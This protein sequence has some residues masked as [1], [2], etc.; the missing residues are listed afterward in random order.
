MGFGEAYRE[1]RVTV[2]GDLVDAAAAAFHALAARQ[3]ARP[4]REGHGLWEARDNVHRHYDLGND[5]Y[6]AWLDE[7]LVYTCAYFPSAG[8]SLEEAQVAKMERRRFPRRSR[9][10]SSPPGCRCSTSRACDRIYARTLAQ[11]R[12]RFE[13]AADQLAVL[14]PELVRTWRL[15]LAGSEAAFRTGSLQLFQVTFAGAA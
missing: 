15:Y 6:R 1:G 5:F 14:G 11:W 9:E 7:Q 3:A 2:D 10:R 4:S 12:A 8:C 13:R